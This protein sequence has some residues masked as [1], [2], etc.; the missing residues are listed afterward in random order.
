MPPV[1]SSVFPP[2]LAADTDVRLLAGF[3]DDGRPIATSVAVRTQH[4]CGIYAARRSPS[5]RV[6]CRV[7]A[8]APAL[9]LYQTE[10][11]PFS[12]AVRELLTELGI[13]VV[14]RQ[15]EP[16]PKERARLREL[17]GGDGIPVLQTEDGRFYRG[18]REIFGYL[19]DREPTR[20]TAEH[21]HRFLDHRDARETDVTGQLIEYFRG[22]GDLD[23]AEVRATPSEAQ[24]I[25]VPEKNRYE[26][27]LDGRKIGLVAYRR[28]D[29]VVVLTHTE[30]APQCEG[31]GFGGRLVREA[32]DDIRSQ[33]LSVV[34]LCPFVS[35]YVEAHPE[36]GDLVAK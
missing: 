1:A 3:G 26:L 12:S 21:R 14:L 18:T 9:T 19:H 11:C 15:V 24:V 20:F 5:R 27:R 28:R 35:H 22:T 17:T 7:M 16:F 23:A 13:D 25:H 4:V 36:Y 33:G 6:A 31:R 2:S 34:P 8:D 10:W 30:I 32:L 29:D